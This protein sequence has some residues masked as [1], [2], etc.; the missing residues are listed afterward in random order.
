[1]ELIVDRLFLILAYEEVLDDKIA[2]IKLHL[3]SLPALFVRDIAVHNV[4]EL[5][6][7]EDLVDKSEGNTFLRRII[8]NAVD[9]LE[10]DYLL[11]V[12]LAFG[13]APDVRFLRCI[14]VLVGPDS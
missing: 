11:M 12:S 1:M 9:V 5:H 7:E 2:V 13:Q 3:D 10:V 4:E 8:I 6:H 14:E